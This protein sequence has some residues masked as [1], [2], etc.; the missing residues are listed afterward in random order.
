M[1]KYI[2]IGLVFLIFSALEIR[3]SVAGEQILVGAAETR[4]ANGTHWVSDVAVVNPSDEAAMISVAFFA[5]GNASGT[6][7]AE[8]TFQIDSNEEMVFDDIVSTLGQFGVAGT[9]VINSDDVVL[10]GMRTYNQTDNGT[11]GQ[12]VPVSVATVDGV[13]PGVRDDDDFRSNLGVFNPESSDAGINVNGVYQALAPLSGWQRRFTDITGPVEGS[14]SVLLTG[15]SVMSY[16][17]VVDNHSGDPTYL[18]PSEP[19]SQGTL[20]GVAHANGV[21]SS[22]WRTDVFVYAEDSAIVNLEFVPWG[23][24][25]GVSL[26]AMQISAGNNILLEDVVAETGSN[27]GGMLRWTASSDIAVTARTYNAGSADGTFGQSIMPANIIDG[28]GFFLFAREDSEFRANLALY[29]PSSQEVTYTVTFHGT[30]D[31]EILISVP[32]GSSDQIGRILSYRFWLDDVSGFIT[33]TGGPFA[34]Y[35]SVVDN[36]TGDAITVLP[37]TYDAPTPAPE[38]LSFTAEISDG[39]DVCGYPGCEWTF[40]WETENAD[41]GM[42]VC[43][44]GYS[45]E[46]VSDNLP[47]G[48]VE[49]Y[50]SETTSCTLTVTNAT[51]SVD[52]DPVAVTVGSLAPPTVTVLVN[53]SSSTD[54][55]RN[56]DVAVTGSATNVDDVDIDFGD[57]TSGLISV[58]DDSYDTSVSYGSAGTYQVV[59]TATNDTGSASADATVN[60]WNQADV[61]VTPGWQ[62]V[63]PGETGRVHYTCTNCTELTIDGENESDFSGYRSHDVGTYE[64]VGSNPASSD[65]QTV[66]VDEKTSSGT[67]TVTASGPTSGDVGDSLAYSASTTGGYG[68]SSS[69]AWRVRNSSGQQVSYGSGSSFNW[70]PADAGTYSV[71]VNASGDCSQSDEDSL[72]VT[73]TSPCEAPVIG[74]FY[75][76]KIGGS[77]PLLIVFYAEFTGSAPTTA[78][79]DTDDGQSRSL[80]ITEAS[81][82]N[83]TATGSYTYENAG[84]FYPVLTVTND[85]GSDEETSTPIDVG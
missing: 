3:T 36:S 78:F 40:S 44:D 66:V 14:T 21:G 27:A 34:G 80:S 16:L 38:V 69:Y 7:D 15:D 22:V 76:D 48:S 59:A 56:A 8:M 47:A 70:T 2:S 75:P 39:S 4:G 12:Y 28:T 58:V 67:F 81:P 23:Q 35:L 9:L 30:E 61:Y 42:V 17:S 32:A 84:T 33:V 55:L 6:P 20:I 31:H 37:Q 46:L 49:H 10:T 26:P 72:T 11:Y 52:S 51:G 1:K 50:F 57:G 41:S 5:F 71:T 13:I 60:V 64:Y 62:Q 77:S 45:Y 65:S 74:T 85:C 79:V 82:G 68:G 24:A 54:V 25:S 73:V 83:Y 18:V 19:S 53:G 43:E 63:C 29:N